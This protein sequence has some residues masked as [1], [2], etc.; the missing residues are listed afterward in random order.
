MFEIIIAGLF[1]MTASLSGIFFV[2]SFAEKF[3]HNKIES[4]VSFSAGVFI[5]TSASLVLEVFHITESILHTF[6]LVT[7]GYLAAAL[8]HRL[9]PE[10]H[11][12]HDETCADT[13]GA[14]KII[15]GDA[16]HNVADGIILVPAFLI[17]G[18][19][20][21][22][23]AVSI[24]IHEL[25]QEISEFFI[26]KRAGY[27]TKKALSIN[28]LVSSTIFIGI[29]IGFLV[30]E[31]TI[32]ESVLLAI[33]GGFFIH[34]V[35]HD[36]LPRKHIDHNHNANLLIVILGVLMMLGVTFALGESHEHGES[37]EEEIH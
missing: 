35:I 27:S 32:L 37:H 12:H 15:I 25:L 30:S 10:T 33:S 5:V 26:L 31:N 23:V 19:L 9:L 22:V 16:I 24:F 29:A 2:S 21:A 28:F 36:L 13:R 1:I 34:I 8:L 6:A 7:T 18:G 20:G 17:S 11:H 4:L 14:R 3:L